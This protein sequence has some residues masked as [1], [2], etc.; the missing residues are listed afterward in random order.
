MYLWRDIQTKAGYSDAMVRYRNSLARE[1]NFI[2]SPRFKKVEEDDRIAREY[3]GVKKGRQRSLDAIDDPVTKS[4]VE[5][6]LIME[7]L[8]PSADF[9]AAEMFMRYFG[10]NAEDVGK[11]V[12]YTMKD[13]DSIY[14]R[15]KKEKRWIEA[16]QFLKFFP[17][18]DATDQFEDILSK[19]FE[20]KNSEIFMT[21]IREMENP[22]FD[23]MKRDAD[24]RSMIE[25]ECDRA[26]H[27]RRYEEAKEIVQILED[28]NRA[29][30]IQAAEALLERNFDEAFSLLK[31][32]TFA[33]RLQKLITEIHAEEMKKGEK[34]IEGYR[35]AY[36][37]AR[38]GG[39][40]TEDTRR[41]IEQPAN[42]LLEQLVANPNATELDFD[43][44]R[45][46]ASHANARFLSN[47][48]AVKCIDLITQN[49][50]KGAKKLKE[51]F[52]PNFTPGM[53][54]EEKQVRSKFAQL[55]E[56][57]GIHDIPKG[58]EN[59]QMAYDI[60]TIFQF[61]KDELGEINIKLCRFYI[62]NKKY[63]KAVDFFDPRNEDLMELVESEI[64]KKVQ[65]GDYESPFNLIRTLKIEFS[66]KRYSKWFPKLRVRLN[67]WQA[68]ENLRW[69]Q[70]ECSL[71]CA[72]RGMRHD[73]GYR[74]S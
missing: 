18:N 61:D 66:R 5:I 51:M 28:H 19:V 25:K 34:D 46:Y 22:P 23:R 26:I 38:H 4:K 57:K 37:L 15:M 7:A 58:E 9:R 72:L 33:N 14:N 39:L 42:K 47:T 20:S 8:T 63:E 68:R 1:I 17:I 3:E 65:V 56:T 48:I 27:E 71:K 45:Q 59:L 67:S 24:I 73:S 21:L 32:S 30:L 44:A 40:D 70:A 12:F 6:G 62:T 2:F 41:Y 52:D 54:D 50:S 29:N 11:D 55:T 43:E 31:K 49:D 13:P 35:N 16:F 36:L 74:P 69:V 53:Y 10:L 60:A 64:H